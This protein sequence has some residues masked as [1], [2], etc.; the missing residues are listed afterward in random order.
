MPTE[1]FFHDIYDGV[2]RLTQCHPFYDEDRFMGADAKSIINRA[3]VD[4]EY[5]RIGK[6]PTE[7][8]QLEERYRTMSARGPLDLHFADW[9]PSGTM[10]QERRL[11]RVSE[12]LENHLGRENLLVVMRSPRSQRNV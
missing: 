8:Y 10:F 9:K 4:V 7:G 11:Q 6:P 12:L 3:D 1:I 5:T 2:D